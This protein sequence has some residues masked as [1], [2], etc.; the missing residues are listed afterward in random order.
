MIRKRAAFFFGAGISKPSGKPLSGEITE[1][2]LNDQWW[3]HS[4]MSFVPGRKPNAYSLKLLEDTVTP[5]V[6][7]FLGRL[8]KLAEEYIA[9]LSHPEKPRL[10]HYEDLFGLAE[11]AFRSESDHVPNLAIV[12]FLRRLRNET[13]DLHGDFKGGTSGGIGLAGLAETACDFLHWVVHHKLA[14]NRQPR[15]GLDA[16][17]GVAEHVDQLDI[18][19]LNHDLLVE[20]QLRSMKFDYED[21]FDNRRGELRVFSFWPTN[22]RKKTRIFKLHGSIDWYFYEFSD[23][24]RQYAIP[25]KDPS[26]SY[27]QNKKLIRPLDS[28]AA[29]LSGT[30]VKER[31]YGTGVFGELFTEFRRHLGQHRHLISSGYGFGDTGINNRIHQWLCDL[32]NRAN[33]LVVLSNKSEPK[34]FEDKPIWMRD[35]RSRGQLILVAKRLQDCSTNDLE[36]Y[37]DNVKMHSAG[38][39]TRCHEF[40][41]QFANSLSTFCGIIRPKNFRRMLRKFHHD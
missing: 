6:Q 23:G 18:F 12:E 31:R 36:P 19:T 32:P 24:M 28:K 34:F 22:A 39:R 16:I 13:T 9:E 17:T 11:Q 10:I 37:F 40:L 4:D 2:A 27:D 25:D 26:H 35:M 41:E 30:V 14:G 21:G 5:I 15:V 33:K 1:S 7:Q 38:L 20:A 8:K 3:L 29:F